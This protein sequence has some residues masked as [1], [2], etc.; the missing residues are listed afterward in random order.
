MPQSLTANI[1]DDSIIKFSPLFLDRQQTIP[2]MFNNFSFSYGHRLHHDIRHIDTFNEV[3]SPRIMAILM[4]W[5]L[6]RFDESFD[7]WMNRSVCWIVL[8]RSIVHPT[9]VLLMIQTLL[10]TFIESFCRWINN[11]VLFLSITK[12][13]KVN[14]LSHVDLFDTAS[15][16]W[17]CWWS[18]WSLYL[19]RTMILWW[20]LSLWSISLC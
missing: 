4:F 5:C 16:L 10:M 9:H 6:F 7:C 20:S 14:P 11:I 2:E 15:S 3:G 13:N 12:H 8:Y 19:W 17:L 1:N 18:L